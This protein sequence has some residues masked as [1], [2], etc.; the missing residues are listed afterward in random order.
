MFCSS[1]GKEVQEGWTCCPQCGKKLKEKT[2]VQEQIHM[3]KVKER[4][5]VSWILLGIIGLLVFGVMMVNTDDSETKP[6][7]LTEL[8]VID[9][10]QTFVTVIYEENNKYYFL[11]NDEEWAL[12]Y[13]S[14]NEFVTFENNTVIE[15]FTE[16]FGSGCFSKNS[17]SNLGFAYDLSDDEARIYFDIDI[18]EGHLTIISYNL[19]NKEYELMIDGR[20]WSPTDEFVDFMEKYELAQSIESDVREFKALLQQH[21]LT[22]DDLLCIKFDTLKSQFIPDMNP[23]TTTVAAETDL[24]APNSEKNIS[25]VPITY[26]TYSVDN[27]I[28]AN[29]EAE[30]GFYTEDGS[31]YIKMGALSYGGRYLAVFEGTLIH[32]DGNTYQAIE[33][34]GNIIL[35]ITFDEWGMQVKVLASDFDEIYMLEGYYQ[36]TS[37]LN[38]NEVG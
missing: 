7:S 34:D 18:K 26:G 25:S 14:G 36:K 23:T 11:N 19:A 21:E 27:G 17:A 31:D 35:E 37:E 20:K 38:L 9:K 4:P 28:D 6:S 29:L 32:I 16:A 24:N 1:C 2:N 22:I 30:V 12:T 33:Y 10:L 13:T 5:K 15:C 3:E 8:E